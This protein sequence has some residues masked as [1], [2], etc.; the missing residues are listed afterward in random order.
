M[1]KFQ[2]THH[3]SIQWR[4][5]F[6]GTNQ[7]T[8]WFVVSRL[9][10]NVYPIVHLILLYLARKSIQWPSMILVCARKLKLQW[11][12]GFSFLYIFICSKCFQ[13]IIIFDEYRIFD[14]YWFLVC[15]KSCDWTTAVFSLGNLQQTIRR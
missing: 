8:F 3:H 15:S 12:G 6:L 5:P 10:L 7:I 11:R 4:K 13:Y 9:P 2:F 14:D 1:E